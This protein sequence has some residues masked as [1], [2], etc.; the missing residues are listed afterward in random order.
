MADDTSPLPQDRVILDYSYYGGAN[1]G[2]GIAAAPGTNVRLGVNEFEPGFEKT[3]LSGAASFELRAPMSA[4]DV[5]GSNFTD[6]GMAFKGLLLC[7]NDLD[8]CAGMSIN[9]PTCPSVDFQLT[10]LAPPFPATL[11]AIFSV[12]NEAVHLLPFVG[13]LW[14]PSCR[15]FVQGYIQ[16][17]VD[18]SGDQVF[19]GPTSLGR[20][21]DPTL[22]Y[23]DLGAGYWLRK[24]DC[25]RLV[26]GLALIGEIHV[27]ESVG[28]GS[29]TGL[30]LP[31]LG[32]VPVNF[33]LVDMDFGVH[34]EMGQHSNVTCAYVTPLSG[35]PDRVIDGG[36][37]VLYNYKF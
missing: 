5:I 30:V 16:V 31:A 28:H 9:V 18:A 32:G 20:V 34:L 26:S 29:E 36:L 23:V 33:S 11:P 35:G 6:L 24:G 10:G 13:A 22:L 4:I 37:R 12:K 14:R 21:Y 2:Q 27:N 8:V 17:D 1:Y 25:S 15:L 7:E 3:F 19:A